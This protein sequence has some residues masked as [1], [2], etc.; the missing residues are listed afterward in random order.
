[1]SATLGIDFGTSNSA[2]GICR[3]GKPQLIA[4]EGGEATMPTAVFFDFEEKQMLVGAAASDA[5]L[6][7]DDG[8]YM[9]GLK[10]LL[11]TRLIRESR[12]LL[13]ERLDFIDIVARFLTEVKTRAEAATGQTFTRA[14]SGRPVRFHSEDDARNIQA[15][16]DLKECYAR[17][18]FEDVRFL[19]EPEAAARASRDVLN[20]GDLGLVVDIGG[21]T[22]DFTLFRQSGSTDIDILAS[23]GVRIGG[24]DFD[25]RLSIKRV[26]PQLGMGSS[27]RHAFGNDTHI[28]PNAI[29]NDLATW[30]KIPFLYGPDTL[31]AAKD[32]HK[33]AVH[34]GRLARLVKVLEEE[35]GHDLAFAVEAGKIMANTPGAE[36]P[37]IKVGMLKRKA[38]LPLPTDMM[39]TILAGLSEQ[40]GAAAEAT[41]AAADVDAQ[42]VNK[43][44]FVGGSSLMQVVQD[45]LTT[46][47][48]R[49]E[50]H[51][52]AAL[53]GIVDGLALASGDGQ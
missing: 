47:L 37:V 6:G 36:N 27:I 26:M 11:G 31:R 8:R 17:A 4:L 51:R 3:D 34:E 38:V 25:R 5:L 48:P 1:M 30:A 28:A 33:Y 14:V 50:V 44:I 22:S 39:T 10:S 45:A 42:E 32:L 12:L 29:F 35:L 7:G 49:A 16:E 15:L 40:I 13:G 20:A 53:T 43:L 46:R 19:N 41:L 24:T 52:G 2:A 18:G 21:G 23:Y 9:R